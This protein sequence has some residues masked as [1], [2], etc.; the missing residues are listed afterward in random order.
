MRLV[1]ASNNKGKI[2]EM[3]DLLADLGVE[4][5][6]Q[7]EAGF[8]EDVDETG[9]TFMENARLK[10][11]AASRALGCAVIADDSGL[12]V[13]ALNGEPGVYSAR[14][15]GNHDDSDE[16]RYR[17]LL[18]KMEGITDRSARFICS[19]CC[20]MED[21]TEICADG[22]CEGTILEEPRGNNGFGYDPVFQP[23]GYE[24]SMAELGSVKQ[25]ISH[26]AYALTV[27]KSKLEEYFN[28]IDQ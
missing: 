22:T 8:N 2:A 1:I 4:I 12:A 9:T 3:S 5:I 23:T 19:I 28:G 26:R 13:D 14:Y 18:K 24:E 10:A 17:Y 20:I 6:S 27:F 15:T 21:G 7:R 11:A 25:Q 16:D